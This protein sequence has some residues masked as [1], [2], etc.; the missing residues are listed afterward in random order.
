MEKTTVHKKSFVGVVVKAAMR[1]TA[2]VRIDRYE[3]HPKYKKY[4]MRSKTYL[5]HD[6]GNTAAVG[7]TVTITEARPL[8]KRKRFVIT[9]RLPKGAAEA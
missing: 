7:D 5:A 8:S 1:D 9:S 4:R 3:K 2:T 6:P